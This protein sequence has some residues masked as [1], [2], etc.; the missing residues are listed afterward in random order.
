[1][2]Q[3]DLVAE[4]RAAH[5]EAP[6]EVRERVRLIA[7]A[8]PAP[9]RRITWRRALVVVV[10]V[11]AAIAA[12]I[13]FTRPAKHAPDRARTRTRRA[14]I[15]RAAAGDAGTRRGS[16]AEGVRRP[17][18][19]EPRPGLRRDAVAPRRACE[20]RLRRRQA[21][22]PDR[23]VARRLLR[24]GARRDARLERGRRPE[25]EDPARTMCSRRWRS[26]RSSA[27]SPTRTCRPSTRP[28][29]LNATD[30]QIARLQKQLATLRAEPQSPE[31]DRRILALERQIV[32]L[33]RSEATTRLNAHYA[34]VDLH[35]ETP[36]VTVVPKH[37][38]GPLHGARCRVQ[39]DRDRRRLRARA[40]RS[41]RACCSCLLWLG[42]RVV[43]QAPRERAARDLGRDPRED[44]EGRN[45]DGEL[46]E[47]GVD[48]TELL[49]EP[50]LVGSLDLRLAHRQRAAHRADRTEAR[51]CAPRPRAACRDRSR[52]R[53]PSACSRRRCDPTLRTSRRTGSRARG[54]RPDGRP[55]R[56]GRR[57]GG[58]PSRPEG[59]AAAP[60]RRSALA[61]YEHCPNG[62]G[63]P[64]DLTFGALAS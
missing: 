29:G 1:M 56:S 13:V 46:V 36:V 9:P 23:D 41:G 5:V 60:A 45:T 20:R 15:D 61:S 35:L 8:A 32:R 54:T 52:P 57:S 19:E 3:R 51:A 58:T 12:T 26:S 38:H 49:V 55:C 39:V 53:T 24:V 11:A 7:A 4:L 10:P 22:T 40:R 33:Q 34:T 42:V 6:P 31:N 2:S 62:R 44:A 30:R 21:R 64:Q 27:R 16:G 63:H 43:R 18:R 48:A 25:A 28:R 50:R 14:A 17:V 37:G 59:G 47:L